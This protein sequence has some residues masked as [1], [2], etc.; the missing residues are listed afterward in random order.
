MTLAAFLP[1][2]RLWFERQGWPDIAIIID[3]SRSMSAAD[4]YQDPRVAEAAE[5]LAKVADLTAPERLQLAQALLTQGSPNWLETL[6]NDRQVKVPLPLSEIFAPKANPAN[7]AP[8]FD[9]SSTISEAPP[10]RRSLC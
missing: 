1:Q 6:L 4:N 7:W 3:D 8:P 2:I 9:R 5:R 10:C